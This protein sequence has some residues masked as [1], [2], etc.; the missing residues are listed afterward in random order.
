M[1]LG[2][3]VIEDPTFLW[4][5]VQHDVRMIKAALLYA[6]RV[7]LVSHQTAI[8]LLGIRLDWDKLGRDEQIASIVDYILGGRGEAFIDPMVASTA[9]THMATYRRLKGRASIT[10]TKNERRQLQSLERFLDERRESMRGY[11]RMRA[12][13]TGIDQIAELQCRGLLELHS[14]EQDLDDPVACAFE[15][16]DVLTTAITDHRTYLMFDDDAAAVIREYLANTTREVPDTSIQRARQTG[17]AADLLDRLPN[18]EDAPIS[19][20]IQL[21][22]ELN[23]P[24]A[25]FRSAMVQFADEEGSAPWEPG[26]VLEAQSVFSPDYS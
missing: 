11:Y 6:D 3:S 25:R 7:K 10:L 17:F 8:T 13:Q 23:G 1:T 26:F 22:Q 2:A 5:V 12:E 16:A 19:D 4:D 20:I 9:R 24:L 18:L 14:F 21:R 15:F